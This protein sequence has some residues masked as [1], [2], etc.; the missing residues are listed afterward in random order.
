[1]MTSH[2][3]LSDIQRWMQSVITEPG[4]VSAGI[5][6]PTAREIIDVS[7]EQI[8]SVIRP[9]RQLDSVSRLHV[10]GHAYFARLIECL[11]GEFPAVK[12]VLGEDMFRSFALSYLHERP[13]RSYTLSELGREFPDFLKTTR[14]AELADGGWADFLIDLA[15]LEWTY[16]QV[17]NGPG[18]EQIRTL[19]TEDLQHIGPEIW[20][21]CRLNPIP[22]LRLEQYGFP[23]HEY[24]S[25]IRKQQEPEGFPAAER[26]WLVITRRDYIVRRTPVSEA[27]FAVLGWL[28]EGLEIEETIE[29]AIETFS[30][31]IEPDIPEWF[32]DWATAGYFL[33]LE[34]PD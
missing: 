1:M 25:A 6:S 8:E 27:E 18:I 24:A 17:F 14:P 29:R 5:E 19:Q 12:H 13:S 26:T 20:S 22:C 2:A 15:Q 33:S 34:L 31:Q 28:C 30:G 3:P 11:E 9:S 10:Y 4:G 23:V 16:S 21:R 32:R 7:V